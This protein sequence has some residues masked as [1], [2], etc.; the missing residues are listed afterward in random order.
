MTINEVIAK[1][2]GLR[3]NAYTPAQKTAWLS[4]VDA[5][6]STEVHGEETPVTYVWPDD[7][8]RGDRCRWQMKG[9]E[10]VAAT[11]IFGG[12]FA[13]RTKSLSCNRETPTQRTK[14]FCHALI[15]EVKSL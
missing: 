9:G 7:G 10:R 6:I 11:W 8:E 4:E 3:P 2:D 14:P 15:K 5:K 1:V 13:A 12:R